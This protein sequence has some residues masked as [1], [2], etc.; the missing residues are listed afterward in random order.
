MLSR[1]LL[2][3]SSLSSSSSKVFSVAA[4]SS[5][6]H[7]HHSAIIFLSSLN[8]TQKRSYKKHEFEADELNLTEQNEHPLTRPLRT[9]RNEERRLY[10]EAMTIKETAEKYKNAELKYDENGK[11]FLELPKEKQLSYEEYMAGLQAKESTPAYPWVLGLQIRQAL[12]EVEKGAAASY[13]PLSKY[14]KDDLRV[15]QVAKKLGTIWQESDSK[16]PITRDDIESAFNLYKDHCERIKMMKSEYSLEY[17]RLLKVLIN[18]VLVN[19]DYCQYA[20]QVLNESTKKYKRDVQSI[21]A[22]I[23]TKLRDYESKQSDQ[24]KLLMIHTP[25]YTIQSISK[26]S[27]ILDAYENMIVQCVKLMYPERCS[28]YDMELCKKLL[29][30]CRTSTASS[31]IERRK[32]LTD[33]SKS[34]YDRDT[35]FHNAVVICKESEH[36]ARIINEPYELERPIL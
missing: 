22:D 29:Y 14:R 28:I 25:S 35:L 34:H 20:K 18:M 31:L 32:E 1:A 3:S 4:A 19:R 9:Y 11:P 21:E 17:T 12:Y 33:I 6:H 36:N 15:Y 10:N 16:K 5:N 23:E 8:S 13:V 7:H 30:I 26:M 27:N 2:R 24:D